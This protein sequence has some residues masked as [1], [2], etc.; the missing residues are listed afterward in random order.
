MAMSNSLTLVCRP[1][2]TSS[3]TRH[4]TSVY[5][6]RQLVSSLLRRLRMPAATALWSMPSIS[7][8]QARI[9][10]QR[11]RPI[12]ENWCVRH[13]AT[14][15]AS[16]HF[17]LSRHTPRSEL[18]TTSPPRFSSCK[19]T[20]MNATGGHLALLCSNVWSDTHRFVHK[21]RMRP[22]RRS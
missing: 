16:D 12:G 4:I 11:G 20:A 15:V 5:S 6:T 1:D 9:K 8:C 13:E 18:R 2:F 19:D 14:C 10:S 21:R 17:L 22:T 7:R 3:M